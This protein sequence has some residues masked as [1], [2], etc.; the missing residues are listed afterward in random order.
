MMKEKARG[1]SHGRG[2]VCPSAVMKDTL[3][4]IKRGNY[5]TAT[6]ESVK[7]DVA[8]LKAAP[9]RAVVHRELPLDAFKPPGGCRM[10][11]VKGDTFAAARWL[12][13]QRAKPPP[14]VLDFASDSNP[15]GGCRGD[16]RGT[17]EESLC[18]QSSLLPSLEA[19]PYPIPQLGAVYVPDICVL[20]GPEAPHSIIFIR[21]S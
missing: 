3:N 19:V 12:T 18:R 6:G 15:G 8:R 9:G 20:R 4:I 5:R 10:H 13:S 14:L 11:L 17:Q 21:T 16:Q 2:N 7:L 1:P